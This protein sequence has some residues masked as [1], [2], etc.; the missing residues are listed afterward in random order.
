MGI[1]DQAKTLMERRK[2]WKEIIGAV[3]EDDMTRIPNESIFKSLEE[4]ERI[5]EEGGVEEEA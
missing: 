2:R 3:F 4:L 1:G 5:E